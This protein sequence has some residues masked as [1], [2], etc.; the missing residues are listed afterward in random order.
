MKQRSIGRTGLKVSE[1]CLGTM[2]FGVQCDEAT[3]RA[4]LDKA[5]A[6]G[7]DFLDTADCYPVPLTLETAGRT[8]E[9]LGRWLHG[10]RDRFVVATKC[11]FPMGPGPNDR[12]LSR[13]HVLAAIDASLRRLRTDYVDL[14]Q[15]HAFDLE[16]PLE[17]TLRALDDVVR[18]GKA[19]Y[20]G[21][22]NFRAW[23][24]AKALGVAERLGTARFDCAQP[25]YNVLHREIETELLPLCRAEGVGVIVFNPM[26]G[27]LL[28]GKHRPGSEPDPS[29]RFGDRLGAT[30]ETYRNR[31]W[32]QESLEAVARLRALFE[33]RGKVLPGVAVAWVLAQPG[34]TAAIVGASRPEQ[35][36][37]T[38]GAA[39][40]VLDEEE[41]AALDAVWYQLPRRRPA[42]GPVW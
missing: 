17:E 33:A 9:I 26:A 20:V 28:T 8:E 40:L 30:A 16:T 38:L 18:A 6:A 10:R 11:F 36:D 27:G 12:G 34:V 22:S 3:S 32:Q 5:A 29:G 24:L 15:V 1:I 2:T 39:E 41:R 14:Y 31:Y 13:R 25:R 42:P 4:I 23:E 35:L 19:R 7:V 21:C 37:A